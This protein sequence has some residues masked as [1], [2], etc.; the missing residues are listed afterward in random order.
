MQ[1]GGCSARPFRF[2]ALRWRPNNTISAPCP[3]RRRTLI[4]P[5]KILPRQLQDPWGRHD[6]VWRGS[7]EGQCSSMS[8][9]ISKIKKDMRK[10]VP[11]S[12]DGA[13]RYGGVCTRQTPAPGVGDKI[14]PGFQGIGQAFHYVSATK[15]KTQGKEGRG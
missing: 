15:N 4:S 14:P 5:A 12:T 10:G 13:L 9:C 6:S 2:S 11:K 3:S 8:L 1:E 7:P